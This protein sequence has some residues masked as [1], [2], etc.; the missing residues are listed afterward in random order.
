M[1]SSMF[2]NILIGT[3]KNYVRDL[4]DFGTQTK[5]R[6]PTPTLWHSF[7]RTKIT[8]LH[9]YKTGTDQLEVE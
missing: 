5:K 1:S 2:S 8:T 4:A 9:T 7:V 6:L 3:W